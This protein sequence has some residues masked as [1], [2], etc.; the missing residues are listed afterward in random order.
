M[1][2]QDVGRQLHKD[3]LRS[4]LGLALAR[5]RTGSTEWG[6][7]TMQMTMVESG[8]SRANKLPFQ[9]VRMDEV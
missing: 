5:A 8:D 2:L 4:V 3:S 9:N 1:P 6:R 7:T